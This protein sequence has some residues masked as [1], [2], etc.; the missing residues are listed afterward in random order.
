MLGAFCHSK[1]ILWHN[2]ISPFLLVLI[3]VFLK[4]VGKNWNRLLLKK[5]NQLGSALVGRLLGGNFLL[6]I[7][8]WVG[9]C[10][11]LSEK[12]NSGVATGGAGRAI[13][14]PG[15]ILALKK[16]AFS[17]VAQCEKV[18]YWR[19]TLNFVIL[20]PP[21]NILPPPL[22]NFLATPLR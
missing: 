10:W 12:R 14:P 8:K 15:S 5:K 6:Q 3:H 22:E 2:K 21:W 19:K 20:P 16:Y 18:F 7:S 1:P 13:V 11:A 4:L 9:R 17:W